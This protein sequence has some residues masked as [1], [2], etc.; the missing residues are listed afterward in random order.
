MEKNR[1][2]TLVI[3]NLGM[4]GEGV[5]RVNNEVVF[6]P[7]ALKGETVTCQCINNKNKFSIM[8][9]NKI[10]T[11]S[12]DRVTPKCPYFKKCGGCDLQ[13]LRYE[14]QLEFKTNLVKETMQKVG[15]IDVDVMDCEPSSLV[16]NYRNKA[17]FPIEKTTSGYEIGMYRVNSHNLVNIDYCYLQKQ[18]INTLLKIF[19]KWLHKL[20]MYLDLMEYC[21]DK[22]PTNLTNSPFLRQNETKYQSKNDKNSTFATIENKSQK[23][24]ESSTPG[25]SKEN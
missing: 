6:V 24:K 10:I 13:H 14:K 18:D 19:I 5:A 12:D 20:N 23:A 22:K 15:N 25:D 2:E 8:K 9:V 1:I 11:K 4:N 3:D 21:Y 7:F 17:S 16:Y